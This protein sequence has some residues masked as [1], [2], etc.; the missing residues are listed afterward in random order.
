MKKSIVEK[1]FDKVADGY[2]EGKKKY[3]FYYENLKKFLSSQIPSG[4][5]V[6]EIGC[7]TGDLL[8]ALK[9]KYGYGMDI[10]SKMIEISK[11]KHQKSKNLKF[12]TIW[13]S[14]NSNHFDFIFMSDVVEHL[15]RPEKVFQ[16]V[17]KLVDKKTIFINTMANPI[18]EPLLIFWEK[19]G[20]KMKEGPHKRISYK[21]I[22][23]LSEKAGLK[24]IKHDFKLLI[25]IK[26]PFISV[27]TNKYLEKYLKRFCF[28]EYFV[29]VRS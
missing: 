10:S 26:I 8:V 16:K 18:W 17:V 11:I 5:R 2:D 25:P 28:I 27:F 1:H 23:I 12:S 24:I 19:I 14:R 3:S 15:E 6:F 29:A 21:E 9:P 7:G 22:K 4:K 13:P 20:W